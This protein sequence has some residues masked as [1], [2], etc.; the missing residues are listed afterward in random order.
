MGLN[1]YQ[2]E[3]GLYFIYQQVYQNRVQNQQ[4][5]NQKT[6][7][8]IISL[9]LSFLQRKTYRASPQLY[10]SR[11]LQL[12]KIK[13]L[14]KCLLRK[15]YCCCNLL[16]NYFQTLVLEQQKSQVPFHYCQAKSSLQKQK[17]STINYWRIRLDIYYHFSVIANKD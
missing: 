8:S 6:N 14:S 5:L 11:M 10:N 2:H 16:V 1:K 12:E 4:A 9:Q 15:P 13:V 17:L 3:Q 7:C